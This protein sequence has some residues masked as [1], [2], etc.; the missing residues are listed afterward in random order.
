MS[1]LSRSSTKVRPWSA[2]SVGEYLHICK[3]DSSCAVSD[4]RQEEHD[5]DRQPQPLIA[6]QHVGSRSGCG[7]G[8]SAGSGSGSRPSSALV[9][10]EK[11]PALPEKEQSVEELLVNLTGW[12]MGE[13][14]EGAVTTSNSKRNPHIFNHDKN[15]LES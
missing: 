1:L 7:S 10:K 14:G 8:C 9:E 5:S 2:S 4:K 3:A 11:E 13:E 15:L 12:V 6:F